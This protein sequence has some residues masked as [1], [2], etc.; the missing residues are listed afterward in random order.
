MR[1]QISH[2]VDEG[3]WRD[4]VDREPTATV[5]HTPDMAEVFS[6]AAGHQ[7]SLWAA[8]DD[9]GDVLALLTPVR[10]TLVDGPL[11]RL[12]S[13]AV[14]YGGL[15]CGH[16]ELGTAAAESLLRAYARDA[17][18]TSLF[19]EL[20]H[21]HAPDPLRAVLEEAG[22]EGEPHLNILVGLDVTEAQLWSRLSRSAKH[23]VRKAEKAGVV[24]EEVT[25]RRGAAEAYSI[26][27]GVYARARVPLAS[28]SLF[29]AAL[30]VLQPRGLLRILA[31]RLGDRMIGT[32]LLLVHKDRIIEWY[33]GTDREF[34][35]HCP[36]ELLIWRT[37]QW[38]R[39][40]GH[41]VFDFGGAGRPDEDYGPRQFKSKW[42]GE[43]VDL[44]R[45]VLV[46]S[47]IRLRISQAGYAAA[48]RLAW[49]RALQPDRSAPRSA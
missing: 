35:G 27:Q 17:R 14:A 9:R 43:V 45:H 10:V 22:F 25:D 46:H 24:V 29:D 44:G 5:Y 7:S 19:T 37:L 8:C 41:A 28:R 38:G 48:R 16:D 6:R 32:L 42:G 11:R 36:G 2:F 20:R 40:H 15:A 34:G 13:R 49:T 21:V 47:P 30:E 23:N 26:L 18:R 1:F 33:V 39:E 12:T 31:A 4:F 3:A